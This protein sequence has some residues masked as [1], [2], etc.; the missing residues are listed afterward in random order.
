LA[1]PFFGIGTMHLVCVYIFVIEEIVSWTYWQYSV[2]LPFDSSKI[3]FKYDIE[4]YFGNC[5]SSPNRHF[6][7]VC[8][9]SG[10][11]G[12]GWQLLHFRVI[13]SCET[14]V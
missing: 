12:H 10:L 11:T 8:V 7:P 13:C 6:S 2:W 9:L 14:R 3:Q 4:R 1:L 5:Q